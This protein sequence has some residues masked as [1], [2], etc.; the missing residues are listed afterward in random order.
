M[1]HVE[2]VYATAHYVEL[3]ELSVEEGTTVIE[4][5]NQSGMAQLHPEARIEQ[6]YIGIYGKLCSID[7]KLRDGDRIEIYRQLRADPKE[8]RR[9]RAD[10]QHKTAP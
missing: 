3:I 7:T 9:K 4:A 2:V 1:I 5:I 10:R 6:G 8:A